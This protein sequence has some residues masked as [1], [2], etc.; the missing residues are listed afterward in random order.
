MEWYGNGTWLL[1]VG[2]R[3]QSIIRVRL[4]AAIS[5][6]KPTGWLRSNPDDSSSF[7]QGVLY[8]SNA[9]CR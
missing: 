8:N 5:H 4:Q 1:H 6:I 9:S 3:D 2:A 7:V